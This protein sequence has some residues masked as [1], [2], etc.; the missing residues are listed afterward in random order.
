VVV[1]DL[2]SLSSLFLEALFE[3]PDVLFELDSLFELLLAA[4]FEAVFDSDLSAVLEAV[5]AAVAGLSAL[6]VAALGLAADFVA[7]EAFE[8][9]AFVPDDFFVSDF[10]VEVAMISIC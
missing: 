5:F 9:V 4:G 10:A 1:L 3:P 6:F 7:V 2:E 8:A